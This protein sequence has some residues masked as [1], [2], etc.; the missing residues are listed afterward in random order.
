[1]Q[2][3]AKTNEQLL[4]ELDQLQRELAEVKD[5]RDRQALEQQ[6][7]ATKNPGIEAL[8]AERTRALKASQAA[9]RGVL[10]S[11]TSGIFA[12]DAVRD[13]S[14]RITDFRFTLVNPMC[15]KM[16]FHT[17]ESL[18]G[19]TLLGLFPGVTENGLFDAYVSVTESGQPAE[20]ES[21][22]SDQQLDFWLNVSV[23]KVG[24]GVAVTFTDITT[25]KRAE[26]EAT[27]RT[28]AFQ[29]MQA[30]ELAAQA[31]ELVAQQ[32]ELQHSNS[33]L[34]RQ[35]RFAE[36]LLERLP[37]GVA[38]FDKDLV[39]RVVNPTM[40][41]FFGHSVEEVLGRH[42][43]DVLPG[44][45]TDIGPIYAQVRETLA[46]VVVHAKPVRYEVNGRQTLT[47]W[48]ATHLPYLDEQG[49][50]DGWL[51]LAL[52]VSERVRTDAEL[53]R[54]KELTDRIIENTPAAIGYLNKDLVFESA[55]PNY[56]KL[57]RLTHEQTIGHSIRE[58]FGA[59]GEAQVGPLLRGVLETGEPYF[60]SSFPFKYLL[61][62][63]EQTT[64]WDFT[65][66]PIRGEA[67]DNDGVMILA[68]EV[69]ERVEKE[70]LQRAHIQALEEGEKLKDQFLS[71]LSH[72]LRTPINAIMG[73]GSILD[74]EVVGPLNEEQ[75]KYT[76]R[77]LGGAETL[78]ALINDLLDMSRIQAGKFALDPKL[79]DPAPLANEVVSNLLP[80][81]ERKQQALALEIDGELPELTADPQRLMQ[82][83]VNLVGNA[84]KFTP[85]GGRIVVRA[86]LDGDQVRFQ[87]QDTGGGIAAEDLAKLFKPFTQLDSS[88]TRQATGTGLGLAITRNL[89]EAHGGEIGVESELGRGSTFW[90]TLPRSPRFDAPIPRPKDG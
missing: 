24:D 26:A 52:E 85:D 40:A 49:E 23:V 3:P 41:R 84:V 53:S 29:A 43:Y 45:E 13:A 9:L 61:N 14:G 34:A 37:A 7:L 17:A 57:L 46:P 28:H 77:I 11:A 64:Y 67:G 87:V 1:M 47:H 20:V 5:E 78:L 89:V 33:E 71:I 21:Y 35:R 4:A 76:R 18:L 44:A 72:E 8:A 69:S 73:F 56:L 30:E 42:V 36:T 63:Q 25:R 51:V 79:I 60:A 2:P 58:V 75:H 50:F 82:I 86:R 10:D 66:Q 80:L 90:F 15:E 88:L 16:L 83:L 81:A 22:Y 19:N 38:Y 31:E 48:D 39:F 32:G 59:E 68:M 62:G 6:E 70:Q 74:D 55:N 54:Q 27:Q 12:A 65:Y